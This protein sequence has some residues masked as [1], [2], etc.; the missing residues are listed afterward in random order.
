[1]EWLGIEPWSPSLPKGKQATKG[2]KQILQENAE[3]LKF[4][5]NMIIGSNS[6]YLFTNCLL[7]STF[8]TGELVLF[9][10]A[11]AVFIGSYQFMSYMAK[12]TY[13]QSGALVDGGV[14]LNLEAGIAEHVKDL[15]ILTSACQVLSLASLYVWLLWLLGPARGFYLLWKNLLAPWIFQ[16]A[17]ENQNEEKKQRKMERRLAHARH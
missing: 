17:P 16:P 15:V 4:Y 5:R 12:P 9:I 1:M 2:Q 14:D 10:L 3:T 8:P 7:R 6:I 11:A 13:G